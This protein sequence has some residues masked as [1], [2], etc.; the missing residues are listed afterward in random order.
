MTSDTVVTPCRSVMLWLKPCQQLP[1]E[2]TQACTFWVLY[3]SNSV[4]IAGFFYEL[5]LILFNERS[6]CPAAVGRSHRAPW[7]GSLERRIREKEISEDRLSPV[8]THAPSAH[9][10]QSQHL[11][12]TNPER[13]HWLWRT[14]CFCIEHAPCHIQTHHCAG[15]PSFVF[16]FCHAHYRGTCFSC[17]SWVWFLLPV[18]WCRH[19][20]DLLSSSTLPNHD[21]PSRPS[22]G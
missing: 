3:K 15:N 9:E 13:L 20:L 11:C 22:R 5:S 1:A 10:Q 8:C 14:P 16:S 7:S 6:R 18:L 4:Y 19:I 21:L 17:W 2:F 12:F